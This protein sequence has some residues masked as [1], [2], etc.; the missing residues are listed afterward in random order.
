[1]SEETKPEAI[2]L[3]VKPR[4]L[5][6]NRFKEASAVRN[7]WVVTPED[8]MTMDDVVK[9]EFWAHIGD[10]LRPMDRIEVLPDNGSFFAELI[11]RSCGRQYANV[12]VLRHVEFD[13]AEDRSPSEQFEVQWKGPHHKHAV[14]RLSDK[15]VLQNGFDNK[16]AALAW[17]SSNLNSLAA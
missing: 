14:V 4:K 8:G 10:K 12:Q 5:H 9:G 7:I 1:M 15:T 3:E 11:V 16:S 6:P 17:L 2:K 13:K